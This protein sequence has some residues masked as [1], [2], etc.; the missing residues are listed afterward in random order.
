MNQHFS[1]LLHIQVITDALPCKDMENNPDHS[2]ILL[3]IFI[4]YI[5]FRENLQ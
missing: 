2:F 1:E 4:L 3:G 5:Y